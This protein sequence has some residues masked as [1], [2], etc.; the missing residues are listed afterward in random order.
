MSDKDDT[1]DLVDETGRNSLDPKHAPVVL[2]PGGFDVTD[3]QKGLE[4]A[5]KGKADRRDGLIQEAVQ[6]AAAEDTVLEQR[7]AASVPGYTMIEV[8][9]AELG[10]TERTTVFDQ[11]AWDE[12]QAAVEAQAE[13]NELAGDQQARRAES[14]AKA[15]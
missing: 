11:K 8:E 13:K 12:A 7:D 1:A 4:K 6:G 5:V 3:L 14:E 15:Q 10:V 2:P 9:H